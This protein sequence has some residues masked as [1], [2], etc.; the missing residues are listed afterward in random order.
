L[1]RKLLITANEKPI[2]LATNFGSF[3]FSLSKKVIEKSIMIP[4]H[5]TNPNL[6]ILKNTSINYFPGLKAL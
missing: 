1:S 2:A 3:N 6:N 4:I 5:P